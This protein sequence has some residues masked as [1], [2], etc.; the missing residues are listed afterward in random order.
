M[1][2]WS[3]TRDQ[4]ANSTTLITNQ[5]TGSNS[6]KPVAEVTTHKH[7]AVQAVP[8]LWQSCEVGMKIVAVLQPAICQKHTTAYNSHCD[9][10]PQEPHLQHAAPA[11]ASRSKH[12][13]KKPPHKLM[14]KRSS[15]TSPC[16]A[17]SKPTQKRIHTSTSAA[18]A[19]SLLLCIQHLAAA[20][21]GRTTQA[22]VLPS[23]TET[24]YKQPTQQG[25][26]LIT[27][28]A[29]PHLQHHRCCCLSAMRPPHRCTPPQPHPAQQ[30]VNQSRQVSEVLSEQGKHT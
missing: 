5:A 28:A 2:T 29:L 11:A 25:S 16:L 24:I 18:L 13:N 20:S 15:G 8:N 30:Q 17:F 6:S 7:A 1:Y 9:R 21:T 22:L 4:G 3:S 27:A 19:E 12:N 26:C 10:E 14:H 23:Q